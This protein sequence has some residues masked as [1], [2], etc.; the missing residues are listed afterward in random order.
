M[1]LWFMWF[2]DLNFLICK[3]IQQ[4]IGIGYGQSSFKPH[5][6]E[7]A[8]ISLAWVIKYPKYNSYCQRKGGNSF[9]H[10][11]LWCLILMVNLTVSRNIYLEHLWDTSPAPQINLWARL[12][13][14]IYIALIGVIL[15][16]GSPSMGWG[17]WLNK[18][19]KAFWVL[20]ST[21][22]CFLSVEARR[23]SLPPWFPFCHGLCS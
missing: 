5:G 21:A 1:S 6:R 20:V 16:V 10:V 9:I 7:A 11:A 3:N 22:L 19:K 12:C 8:L 18:K 23:L 2:F 4:V 14:I 17:L 15:T 13:G